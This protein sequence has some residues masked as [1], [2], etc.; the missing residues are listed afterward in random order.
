MDRLFSPKTKGSQPSK[1]RHGRNESG[2]FYFV[3]REPGV[4]SVVRDKGDED[5]VIE[6]H[7]DH[8]NDET[9]EPKPVNRSL[10]LVSSSDMSDWPIYLSVQYENP[11]LL[12][13]FCPPFCFQMSQSG[14][15]QAIQ[16]MSSSARADSVLSI[17]NRAPPPRDGQPNPLSRTLFAIFGGNKLPPKAFDDSG[18][19]KVDPKIFFSLERTFLAWMKASIWVGAISIAIGSRTV[20]ANHGTLFSLFFQAVAILFILY[21]LVSCELE[22]L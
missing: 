18:A 20:K 8:A 3:P 5:A 21:A 7:T 4:T 15:K 14:G 2:Q 22:Q 19:K 10:S 12:T 17:S 9:Y 16:R 1:G 11:H 13:I 6:V